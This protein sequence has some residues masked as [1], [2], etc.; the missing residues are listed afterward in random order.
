MQ[1]AANLARVA[2]G[3]PPRAAPPPPAAPVAV[4]LPDSVRAAVPG[5]FPLKLPTGADFP[6]TLRVEG[7]QVVGQP[8]GQDPNS[9]VY[10]GDHTFGAAFDPTLRLRVVV[11]GGRG[12]RAV[13][14][15]R[16]STV[17]GARTP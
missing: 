5:T 15:R 16:G 8:A 2:L 9:L 14:A 11:E 6:V 3:V 13:L 1:L 10:V 12:V 17:E 4:T 7:G